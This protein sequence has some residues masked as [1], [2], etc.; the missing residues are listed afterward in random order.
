[1]ATVSLSRCADLLTIR[2]CAEALRLHRT[3]IYRLLRR[4][5]RP[6]PSIKLGSRRLIPR[7]G[8]EAW[9]GQELARTQ[10]YEGK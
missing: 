6:L 3:T 1:M 5:H 9:L 7:S 10:R 2:E 8:L 4:P